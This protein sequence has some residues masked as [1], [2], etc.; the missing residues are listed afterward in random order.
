MILLVVAIVVIFGAVTWQMTMSSPGGETSYYWVLLGLGIGL[1]LAAAALIINSLFA[2]TKKHRSGID[3]QETRTADT[4]SAGMAHDW[5]N[6]LLVLSMEASR[7][8]E[9]S[10]KTPELEESVAALNQV[11]E[12]GR[13]LTEELMSLT[14]K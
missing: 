12:E 7:L 9:L 13:G 11:V 1:A 6:L 10:G 14:R 2:G 4:V 8:E 5:N 3:E